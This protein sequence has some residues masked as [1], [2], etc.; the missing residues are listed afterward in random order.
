MGYGVDFGQVGDALC[1]YEGMLM[2]ALV[3]LVAFMLNY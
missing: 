3:G 1:G 2:N